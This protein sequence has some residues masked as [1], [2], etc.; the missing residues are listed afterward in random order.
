MEIV[1]RGRHIEV[2]DRF[3]EHASQKLAK[4]E[5]YDGKCHRI[6]VEV[7][8]EPNPRLSDQAVRVELTCR[9]KGPVIRAEAA[10]DEKYA[11]LDLAY[12]RLV[13]R[14]RRAADRRHDH[15]RSQGRALAERLNAAEA[16]R[17]PLEL[18]PD[19]SSSGADQ[20][21]EQGPLVVREK[22]H[23][24]PSMT[25]DQALYEMEMVGHDFFLFHDAMTDSPSVVYR[26]K[27]YDY[28]VLHLEVDGL[29]TADA[30]AS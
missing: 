16:S 30:T 26:R 18:S 27:G 8:Q 10:A 5:R 25:I 6:D 2:S 9:G 12:G 24:A 7:L 4:V 1:V 15:R 17:S 28:G 21:T 13:E 23:R 22:T 3:R 29:G 20:P 19:S 11:A 14:L